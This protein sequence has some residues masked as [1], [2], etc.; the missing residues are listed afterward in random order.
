LNLELGRIVERGRTRGA[1]P[2]GDRL[3]DGPVRA[4]AGALPK[5]D[6]HAAEGRQIDANL[7][8]VEAVL[9]GQGL[10]HAIREDPL[11]LCPERQA[12]LSF[13]DGGQLNLQN[14]PVICLLGVYD[15]CP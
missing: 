2:Q 13:G 12:C 6:V 10:G 8:H 3:L 5:A 9:S 1:V 15:G 4:V 11:Y 14:P 7:L